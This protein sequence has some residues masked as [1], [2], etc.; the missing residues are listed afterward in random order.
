MT[1][2]GVRRV[3]K[4]HEM[5]REAFQAAM[6]ILQIVELMERQNTG[7]INGNLSDSGA[8]RAG[9]SIR[10]SMITRLVILVA[11]AFAHTRRDDRH[12]RKAFE[13]V[14][15][16]NVRR[17]LNIDKS[18]LAD[19]EAR[20]QVLQADPRLTAIKHFR[21]KFTA[22]SADPAQGMPLPNFGDM[23]AFAKE[24]TA[25][26]ERFAIGVGTTTEKLSDTDDWRV[27][28][29]QKFW[30]PWEFLRK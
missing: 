25:V 27:E 7:R 24:L 19:A 18:V 28:S 15:D 4:L 22:H 21:D 13:E 10:N 12:L 8:A 16:V 5:A 1:A 23:F 17:H 26:M 29:A 3:L 2:A 30:E 20:W 6:E 11:G 14:S 9:I